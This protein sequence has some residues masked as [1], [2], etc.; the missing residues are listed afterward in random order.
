MEEKEKTPGWLTTGIN[1][2]IFATK[3]RRQQGSQKLPTHY[4]YKTLT[5][6]ITKRNFKQLPEQNLIPVDQKGC[7]PGS[8][9]Y[10]DK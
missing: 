2:R 1:Q 8:N 7:Y 5:G 3:I 4:V 9:G 10:K 6:I